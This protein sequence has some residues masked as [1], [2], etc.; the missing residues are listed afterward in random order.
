L[1]VAPREQVWTLCAC[2]RKYQARATP[3]ISPD[4]AAGSATNPHQREGSKAASADG[5]QIRPKG[6]RVAGKSGAAAAGVVISVD[7]VGW[8]ERFAKLT[9]AETVSATY[10]PY[11]RARARALHAFVGT[12]TACVLITSTGTHADHCINHAPALRRRRGSMMGRRCR[13][14]WYFFP[15]SAWAPQRNACPASGAPASSGGAASATSPGVVAT[16]TVGM[17]GAYRGHV[18]NW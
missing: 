14:G 3:D 17:I 9:A 8:K 6:W 11:K 10:Q 12:G 2:S 16:E 18:R 1:L 5:P 13:C 4:K 15:T 7:G